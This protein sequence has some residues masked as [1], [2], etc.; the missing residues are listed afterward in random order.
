MGDV[1][2][3]EFLTA[4]FQKYRGKPTNLFAY[5]VHATKYLECRKNTRNSELAEKIKNILPDSE[6]CSHG[7]PHESQILRPVHLQAQSRDVLFDWNG[8][9]LLS[10]P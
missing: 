2:Q 9:W 1:V 10:L 6:V 7:I 5:A 4:H 8:F 3:T